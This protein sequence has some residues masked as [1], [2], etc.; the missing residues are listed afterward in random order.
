MTMK[1]KLLFLL[2][3]FF[4]LA[5]CQPATTQGDNP[6]PTLPFIETVTPADSLTPLIPSATI[7]PAETF[8]SPAPVATTMLDSNSANPTTTLATTMSAPALEVA[9]TANR[10]CQVQAD[11]VVYIVKAGDTLWSLAQRSGTSV[12]EVKR[13]N[14][15]VGDTIYAGQRLLLPRTLASRLTQPPPLPTS[16][17]LS[18][19]TSEISSPPEPSATSELLPPPTSTPEPLPPPGPGNPSLVIMTSTG[20]VG[21][22]QH[23]VTLKEFAP[24]EDVTIKVAC[25][26]DSPLIEDVTKV[27]SNGDGSYSFV[28]NQDFAPGYCIVVATGKTSGKDATGSIWVTESTTT[29]TLL[30]SPT[31]ESATT[32]TLMPSPTSEATPVPMP[33]FSVIK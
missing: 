6:L 9:T 27:D 31:T 5:A 21:E 25:L 20:P 24:G 16:G 23:T 28:T 11:W 3:L 18:L 32:P 29:P 2:A 7:M 26:N 19:A 4:N 30:P 14:C 12:A 22:Q 17:P 13:T 10:D 15:L 1:V 8:V 33:M